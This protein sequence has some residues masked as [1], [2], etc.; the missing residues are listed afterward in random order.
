MKNNY[1]F[2]KLGLV[3]FGG[4]L[5]SQ[6]AYVTGNQ[7]VKVEPNTLVYF[8]DD[9]NLTS[10]ATDAKVV[11]NEGNIFIAGE[12]VNAGHTDGKNFVSTWTNSTSYGQVIISDANPTAAANKLAMEK[13]TID[14]TIFQ[15]G[16]FAVPFDYTDAND[17]MNGLFGGTYVGGNRYHSSM[18]V[19]DNTDKPEFDHLNSTSTISPT[20]YV[21]LNLTYNSSGIKSLMSANTKLEYFGSPS[22]EV[23]SGSFST[24]IYPNLAWSAWKNQENSHDEN[25]DTYIHDVKRLA[26]DT[27]YGQDH[28]QFGNP[29]TSNINLSYIGTSSG[30][31]DGNDISNLLSLAK[32]KSALWEED[33]GYSDA[34]ATDNSFIATWNGTN[35]AGAAEAVIIKPFEPFVMVLENTAT[36]TGSIAFSDKLK[37][38]D[39]EPEAG[40]VIPKTSSNFHQLGLNLMNSN[41]SSTFNQVYAVV[42]DNIQNGVENR[43][44]SE[45]SD[46][47]GRTGFY[48]AQENEDGSQVIASDRKMCINVV[49]TDFVSKPIPLFFNRKSGDLEGYY[50]TSD[51]YYQSIFNKLTGEN[52]ITNYEDG[53]SFFFYDEVEDILLPITTDFSYFI[54]P[55]VESSNTR[56]TVYWNGGPEGTMGVG[57]MLTSSTLVYKDSNLHKVR[58]NED[59]SSADVKVYDLA[60]RSILSYSKVNTNSDL[61]LKLISSGVYVVKVIS[62]TGEV[63]TQKIVK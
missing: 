61:E 14:P 39:M 42:S 7:K 34:N 21:I 50:L 22:N 31:D 47:S 35:W 20:S 19:W 8:G 30:Y 17:A 59:W 44:E 16:Q 58:F 38:F 10:G 57:D 43:L 1:L 28:Y 2:L 46:F 13:S 6:S 3:F 26:T 24:G 27:E 63:Y 45:Y 52:N 4:L 53:N 37:T 5:Y 56:F 49:N 40:I 36:G 62:N 33:E 54:A 32:A 15:W 25:Y 18:M 60:G 23:L 11:E 12:F 9:F 55:T 51:L 29:Y 41:G 48:L